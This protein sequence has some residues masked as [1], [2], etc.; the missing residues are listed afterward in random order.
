MLMYLLESES[1]YSKEYELIKEF[2]YAIAVA[3]DSKEMSEHIADK[4]MDLVLKLLEFSLNERDQE[5]ITNA[6]LEKKAGLLVEIANKFINRIEDEEKL[7]EHV[8]KTNE[9]LDNISIY[10]YVEQL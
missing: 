7:M 10:C 8:Q 1:V 2:M 9:C 5:N 3:A 4:C 6:E